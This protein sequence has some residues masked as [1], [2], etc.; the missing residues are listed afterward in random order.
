MKS[1]INVLM[2]SH[3]Y[4]TRV[5][6][7]PNSGIFIK[8]QLTEYVKYVNIN[9]FVPVDITPNM[10]TFKLYGYKSW[11]KEFLN[12]FYRTI[13]IKVKVIQQTYP[14]KVIRFVSL[15]PRYLTSGVVLFLRVLVEIYRV[16]KNIGIIHGQTIIPDG[17]AALLLGK[18][19][20]RP[21]IITARGS[22]VHSIKKNSAA[23]LVTLYVLKRVDIIT[24]VSKN[25][26]NQILENFYINPQKITV[27]NNGVDHDLLRL[28]QDINIRNEL[29]IPPSNR[30]LLFVGKL[31]KVKDPITLIKAFNR[32][33][34]MISNVNLIVVGDGNLKQ[35]IQSYINNHSLN[36]YIHLAGNVSHDRIPYYMNSCDI[37]CLSSLREGWPNVLFEAM[38]FGKPIVAT[39]VGGISEVVNNKKYGILVSPQ[40]P[41]KLSQAML[42]ALNTKW[43][44]GEIQQYA[45]ENTWS[46]VAVKYFKVYSELVRKN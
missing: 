35:S 20:R 11:I 45:K 13:V 33:L 6:K 44:Y 36:K 30:I 46:N 27:I 9:L 12:H 4:P 38:I 26:K 15:Y 32:L 19:F 10:S 31:V 41:E 29:S 2:L 17:C 3:L 28:T 5:R 18:Y 34:L 40:N 22:D 24:V 37:F 8:K 16:N 42:K 25:L 23:Y 21:T 39:N 1:K 43:N 7:N 14:V